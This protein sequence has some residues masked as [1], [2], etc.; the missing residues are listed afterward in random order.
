MTDESDSDP[1]KWIRYEAYA[2]E[3]FEHLS[4][5]L[6]QFDIGGPG[7]PFEFPEPPD[8]FLPPPPIPG[9]VEECVTFS[10]HFDNCDISKESTSSHDPYLHLMSVIVAVFCLIIL[11]SCITIFLVW[12]RRRSKAHQSDIHSYCVSSRGQ[13]YDDLYISNTHRIPRQNQY[14]TQT[15]YNNRNQ[16]DLSSFLLQTSPEGQPIYEEIPP[17]QSDHSSEYVDTTSGYH[18]LPIDSE[19]SES[20]RGLFLVPV[21][22][23]NTPL[24]VS[25]DFQ[26]PG[27]KTNKKFFTFH[28]KTLENS[29]PVQK[30]D[31]IKNSN[32]INQFETLDNFQHLDHPKKTKCGK[33]MVHSKTID[34]HND[35]SIRRPRPVC[36]SYQSN[37]SRQPRPVDNT[38][39]RHNQ[40]NFLP[41][42]AWTDMS[43]SDDWLDLANDNSP[44]LKNGRTKY[45]ADFYE[46]PT[47]PSPP[48]LISNKCSMTPTSPSVIST[49][50]IT[51]SPSS[52]E[53]YPECR[54]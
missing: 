32:I 20:E 21:N 17:G 6:E 7:P 36:K 1:E 10:S 12:R 49:S 45:D 18:T 41:R 19:Y 11:F 24:V 44:S 29:E 8:F 51:V 31:D 33:T 13:F 4:S 40:D 37:T 52:S 53:S 43:G 23:H 54:F 3:R 47:C 35:P 2:D 15:T 22:G 39:Q 34:I 50:D 5:M 9:N 27:G 28:R 16:V 48:D 26:V 42:T 14:C 30:Q 46:R 25:K 38:V